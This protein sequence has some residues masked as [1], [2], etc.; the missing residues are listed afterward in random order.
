MP[1]KNSGGQN[2][3]GQLTEV[4]GTKSDRE[5]NL[6]ALGRG[7]PFEQTA[8]NNG[9]QDID[10]Q[11]KKRKDHQSGKNSG[12]IK[13]PL[14]LGNKIAKAPGGPEILSHYGP[15]Q[16]HTHAGMETGQNPAHGRGH[17]HMAK[18]VALVG[19]QHP[20]V[21]EDVRVDLSDAAIGVKKNDKENQGNAEDHFG[22]DPQT[23]PEGENGGKG[24]PG[25]GVGNL[26]IRV[27]DGR[28][29]GD[30]GE[31]KTEDDPEQGPGQEGQDGFYSGD[32]N[33]KVNGTAGEPLNK[34]E[35]PRRWVG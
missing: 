31:E 13:D 8:L 25:Q 12:G 2:I 6:S 28:Q 7:L 9:D 20:G 19:P 16:S 15:D 34:A 26:D 30:A 14:G 4:P 1:G 35:R 32:I 24:N 22:K 21:I 33:M 11:D 18:E 27:E 3:D 5:I 23:E 17:E 10:D 29:R